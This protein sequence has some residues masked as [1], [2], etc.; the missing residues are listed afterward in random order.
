[1]T[2]KRIDEHPTVSNQVVIPI[3]TTDADGMPINPFK[4]SKV[5]IYFIERDF[6]VSKVETTDLQINGEI[7]T[8]YFKDAIPVEVFGEP[9]N[10]AWLSTDP[11]SALIKKIDFDDEGNPLFGSFEVQWNPDLA[12]EGD[13]VICWSWAAFPAADEQSN[14]LTFILFSDT[15]ANTS[16]PTHATVP[17]KYEVLLDRYLPE[18]IKDSQ[19]G[20]D[21]QTYDVLR[22]FNN[23]VAQGFTTLEDLA[24]QVLDLQDANVISEGLLPLLSNFFNHRLWS[25]DSMLWRRQI[26]R[27]IPLYKKK[28]TLGGLEEALDSAG[29]RLQRLVR[30]WQVVSKITWQEAFIVSSGQFEF[31]LSKLAI[32]PVDPLN[33]EL[34]LRPDGE[35]SYTELSLDYVSFSLAEGK[36]KMT[37]VGH[38][39][40]VDPIPLSPGD[41]VRIVYKIAEPDDQALEDFIRSLPLMDLRDETTFIYPPRNWNVR[42]IEEDDPLF[43][44]V[45]PARH[46]YRLPV[47]WGKVRTEFAY[48]EKVYNMDSYNGSLR[49]SLDPCDIN[50]DFIDVCSDC[51]S[52]KISLTL[53]IENLEN[54]RI[55]EARQIINEMIPFHA[56]IQGINF[57]GAVN[58]FF[59]PPIEEL[60]LLVD[61][62]LNES[63]FI[64]QSD[65]TRVITDAVFHTN[66]IFRDFLAAASTVATATDGVGYNGHFVLFGPGLRFDLMGVKPPPFNL[67]EILSGSNAGTYTVNYPGQSVIALDNGTFLD[68]DWPLDTSEFAFNLSNQLFTDSAASIIQD[69]L[70]VFSHT[71]VEFTVLQFQTVQNSALPW[72]LEITSGPYSGF[73]TINDLLPNNTLIIEGW[74]TIFNVS[75]LIYKVVSNDLATTIIDAVSGGKVSV[76]RRGR[77]ETTDL[78]ND[79]GIRQHDFVRHAGIDY[80]IIGFADDSK[81]YIEGY[82]LG[83]MAG[84]PI[85]IYRRLVDGGLGYLD[86]RGMYLITST[87]YEAALE[88]QDGANPPLV[89]K[90]NNSFKANYLIEINSNYYTVTEWDGTRIDLSGP[91]ID[92]GLGG[93]TGVEFSIIQFTKTEDVV[94]R[95]ATFRIIDRRGEEP[96]T[97]TTETVMPFALQA[98]AAALNSDNGKGIIE[99]IT[100]DES[101]DIEIMWKDGESYKG[102]IW[103]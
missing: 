87:D 99:T 34:Y 55:D 79:W 61:F 5:T 59:I 89:Q 19:L 24:N 77:V 8:T 39:L 95:D 38:L 15:N 47:I 30:L 13:Y 20:R 103:N 16:I 80:R 31:I 44:I 73:Y 42:L 25:S 74:P 63:V 64:G 9:A 3:V 60:E 100:Q 93:F 1:M 18:F 17:R 41:I 68:I 96:I 33:Y 45:I 28:G 58:E 84:V 102:E 6:T 81:A 50:R 52:S 4:V 22:R 65:F 2:I 70:Y 97:I 43:P 54:D 29:I 91:L 71:D 62:Q 53:E 94:V 75:S 27:A 7:V 76:T 10:P 12:R 86:E 48:S 49:D 72:K 69:D 21:D 83:S 57:S 67:L 88:V 40:T 46:P 101:I 36:T 32:L 26:R 14:H 35:A 85:T 11:D 90:E 98:K 92:W 82:T 23:A 78:V 51:Q 66:E 56:E 37:W